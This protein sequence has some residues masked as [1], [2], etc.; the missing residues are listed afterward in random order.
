MARF[1]YLTTA[2]L[3]LVVLLAWVSPAS[4]QAPAAEEAQPAAAPEPSA[5]EQALADRILGDPDAPVTIYEFSS[6]TCPHCATFHIET[7]PVLKEKYIDTGKV[8]LVFKDFP[9]DQFALL[10]GLLARCAPSERYYGFV[11]VLF[12]RQMQWARSRNPIQA[13]AQIGRLG[14]V[15]KEAFDACIGDQD[16]VNGLLEQ[17][18]AA[19]ETYNIQSTP[20]FIFNQGTAR[21]EGALPLERF[22]EVIDRLLGQ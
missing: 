15:S 5:T 9:F 11:D 14:G 8:K 17:R 4:A 21:L 16:L 19:S 10:A 2:V 3:G 18:L 13:L 6:F 1:A 22:V 12:L 7:L 20:T